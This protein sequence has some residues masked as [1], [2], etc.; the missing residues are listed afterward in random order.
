M[1]SICVVIIFTITACAKKER[2]MVLAT[3][4]T[5]DSAKKKLRKE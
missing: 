4:S 5:Q 2:T 3:T 1:M